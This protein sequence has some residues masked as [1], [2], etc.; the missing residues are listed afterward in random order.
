MVIIYNIIKELD[1]RLKRKNKKR[2]RRCKKRKNSSILVGISPENTIRSQPDIEQRSNHPTKT[3]VRNKIL[4][5]K[6]HWI[7]IIM[8]GKLTTH[9]GLLAKRFKKSQKRLWL[10]TP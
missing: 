7:I 4:V 1:R 5:L 10:I 9:R 8:R 3:N 2:T 6:Q